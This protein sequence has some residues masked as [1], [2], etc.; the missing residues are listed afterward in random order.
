MFEQSKDISL[1]LFLSK[2]ELASLTRDACLCYTNV[3]QP[4]PLQ[5]I[6]VTLLRE[7]ITPPFLEAGICTGHRECP[8]GNKISLP[9]EIPLCFG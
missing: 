5:R 6:P 2:S 1:L 9:W 3:T 7:G 4:L 8:L